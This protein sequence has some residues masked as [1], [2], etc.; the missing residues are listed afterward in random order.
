MPGPPRRSD[1]SAKHVTITGGNDQE[2]IWIL[3]KNKRPRPVPV[4]TG[5]SDGINTQILEGE[6][7]RGS[8]VIVSATTKG[9]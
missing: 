6:I 3:D 8:E 7:T 4:K 9:K 2:T 1:R 5:L